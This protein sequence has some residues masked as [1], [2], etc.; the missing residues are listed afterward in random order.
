MIV[1][2]NSPSAPAEAQHSARGHAWRD[3]RQGDMP[4]HLPPRRAEGRGGEFRAAVGRAK[5][6]L[7]G[8]HEERQRDEDLGEHDGA[9]RE[10]HRDPNHSSSA[11]P[12]RPRRPSSC[13]SAMP[14]TTGGSTS[15]TVTAARRRRRGSV[16][17]PDARASS[18]AR[19]T[20]STRH[21]AVAAVAVPNDSTS[22]WST[23]SRARNSGRSAH[24]ARSTRAASGSTSRASAIAAT[25]A[26]GHASRP[27]PRAVVVTT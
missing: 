27:A 5:C 10:R 9:G 17:Q 8:E 13:S 24:G 26:T 6:A 14:P 25:T 12:S 19:G 15:G 3:E 7:D 22:A 21:S 16:G 20:P 18:A 23:D 11:E 4:E 2:P 1:A